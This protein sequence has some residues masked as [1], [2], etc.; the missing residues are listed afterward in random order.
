[1]R[2]LLKILSSSVNK[3]EISSQVSLSFGDND[4]Y[5]WF[6]CY[7]EVIEVWSGCLLEN[8]GV[9][10]NKILDSVLVLPGVLFDLLISFYI[11]DT[12]ISL[13][14][15]V[16]DLNLIV[17]FNRMILN[18]FFDF[19]ST[20]TCAEIGPWFKFIILSFLWFT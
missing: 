14:I 12:H 17:S 7:S 13:S 5:Y 18:F 15:Y 11:A 3:L 2:A 20:T 8:L 6:N 1:M 19:L 4:L 16:S 10:D 9:D